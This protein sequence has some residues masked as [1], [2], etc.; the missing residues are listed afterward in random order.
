MYTV[1]IVDGIMYSM[2]LLED[3]SANRA[4]MTHRYL[5]TLTAA[6]P[7]VLKLVRWVGTLV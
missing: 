7:V 4:R 1:V 5:Y 6:D 3:S 2:P